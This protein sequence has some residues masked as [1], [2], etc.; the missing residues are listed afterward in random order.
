LNEKELRQHYLDVF[1]RCFDQMFSRAS[2]GTD[3]DL[4]KSIKEMDISDLGSMIKTKGIRIKNTDDMDSIEDSL[5]DV[6]NYAIDGL[7][8]LQ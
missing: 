8:R 7:R 4:L 5:I 2:Y 1:N 6:I 3:E